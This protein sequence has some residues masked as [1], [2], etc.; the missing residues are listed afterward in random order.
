MKNS[1]ETLVTCPTCNTPNFTERGLKA[2]KCK[3]KSR[4]QNPESKILAAAPG[5][6][7]SRE[8][9][10]PATAAPGTLSLVP[11]VPLVPSNDALMGQQLTEQYKKA[12]T[13]TRE[14]VVFGAMMLKIRERVSACGHAGNEARRDT[15][16]KAWMEQHAPDV[17]RPTAYRFMAL[18]EGVH[19]EFS[20]GKKVDLTLLL[21]ES[22]DE[23]TPA[24]RKKQKSILDFLEGKSQRQLLLQLGGDD[25]KPKPAR[26][27]SEDLTPEEEYQLVHDRLKKDAG[28][29][30]SG[31]DRYADKKHFQVLNDA[32]LDTAILMLTRAKDAMEAWR[33]MPKGKRLAT[34]VQDSIREWKGASK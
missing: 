17:S 34:A 1:T 26:K 18:A 23:L 5:G 10:Q 30:F 29:L 33:K 11:S 7:S 21:T 6:T 24:L 31:L 12:I 3:G 9:L 19:E 4:I 22:A 8:Q 32:E 20:L 15:G 27:K 2:H 13:A 16:L 14:V 28:E 25:E